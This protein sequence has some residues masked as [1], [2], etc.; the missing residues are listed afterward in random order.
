MYNTST[1]LEWKK[2]FPSMGPCLSLCLHAGFSAIDFKSHH[3]EQNFTMMFKFVNFDKLVR[4]FKNTQVFGVIQ[5]DRFPVNCTEMSAGQ[6][7]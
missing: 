6:K 1:F 3:I 2:N 7:R 5:S 4:N